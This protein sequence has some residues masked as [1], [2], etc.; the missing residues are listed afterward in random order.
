MTT[1]G[2]IP[3]C[4]TC[5]GYVD[6]L[7]RDSVVQDA[8]L[9]EDVVIGIRDDWRTVPCGHHIEFTT[10]GGRVTELREVRP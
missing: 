6:N 1:A 8:R 2:A 9:R 3:A 7:V 10:D 5:G 4:P